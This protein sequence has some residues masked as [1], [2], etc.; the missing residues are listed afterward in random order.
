MSNGAGVSVDPHELAARSTA[1]KEAV[2]ET[3][4]GLDGARAEAEGAGAGFPADLAGPF[5]AVNGYFAQVDAAIVDRVSATA[6]R[7]HGAGA[8]YD[9]TE[10]N[11]AAIL[12]WAGR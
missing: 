2:S 11:N 8:D 4:T 10:R 6:D 7:V 9:A 3:S 5:A 12:Q 1:M